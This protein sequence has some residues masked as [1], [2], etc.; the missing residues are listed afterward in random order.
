MA[1]VRDAMGPSFAALVTVTII[2]FFLPPELALKN[3]FVAYS[4]RFF[5]AYHVGFGAMGFALAALLSNRL[6]LTFGFNRYA[7]AAL[8]LLAFVSALK[9]P[10]ESNVAQELGD[11]SSTSILLGLVVALAVG[12]ILRF[13][14]ARAG[15]M[16]GLA[17]GAGLVVLIFGS[18]AAAHVSLGDAL[19]T[20]IRPL[21]AVGDTLPGLLIVVFLQTLLWTAG[22]HGP[23]FLSGIVTPVFLK[24]LDENGQAMLHHQAPPHVVTMMLASFYFPGGSGATLPLSLLMLRSRVARLRKLGFTSLVPSLANVNELLIFGVPLVMNPS[25]SIPFLVTPLVLAT[26]TYFAMWFGLVARTIYIVPPFLPTVVSGFLSTGDWRAMILVAFNVAV[27]LAIY[28]PFLRAYEQ[29]VLREPSAAARLIRTAEKIREHERE[30][31][32]HPER[33]V[34]R[35]S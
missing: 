29:T 28:F 3:S 18:L 34:R 13:T 14:V 6:A 17:A 15:A 25:L 2:A 27:G 32:L 10:L 12:E 9:W 31:E 5:A 20:A 7:A 21:V 22:V 33:T 23:A 1:A 35:P 30:L 19:L 4:N 26:I 24:A 16:P 8:G 11:I